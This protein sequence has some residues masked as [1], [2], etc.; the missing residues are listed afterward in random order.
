VRA[1]ASDVVVHPAPGP[2]AESLRALATS[3]PSIQPAR[4]PRVLVVGPASGGSLGTARMVASAC[5]AAGA[6]TRFF[7]ASEYGGAYAAFGGLDAPRAARIELQGR[8]VLLI[9]DAVLEVA[10]GFVPDLVLALAQAPLTAPALA[11]LR[12]A[13]IAT[14]FWFVENGRVLTYWRE[15]ARAYDTFYAIQPGRFLDEVRAAGATRAEYLPMACDPSIHAPI[16]LTEEERAR[17]AAPVSFAGAPYVNRQRSLANLVDL[18]LR[19]WGEG[20]QATSLAA[21]NP[22]GSR[23]DAGE[24]V[25]IFAATGVNVNLHSAEHVTGLDDRP[26]YVNPRTFELAACGAFQLVDARDPLPDLFAH[27]EIVT[28]ASV[29]EMRQLVIRY[30]ADPEGRA[31]IAGRARARALRDHT[32]VQRVERIFADVLAPHLVAGA[33]FDTSPASLDAAIDACDRAQPL[34]REEILL[35]MVRS[36]RDMVAS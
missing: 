3:W 6:E 18:G 4:R 10:R 27:D 5:R 17:F 9:G 11:A 33:R 1:L 15:M 16:A 21:V 28:F 14:A 19:V 20:W 25:R 35:R 12:V 13:G 8:L 36:V 24:M 32:Y 26:D 30:L 34:G 29:A 2:S 22:S 7:D 23:F 31:A